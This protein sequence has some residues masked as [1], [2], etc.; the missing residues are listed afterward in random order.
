MDKTKGI[1][2]VIYLLLPL[3]KWDEILALRVYVQLRWG[4]LVDICLLE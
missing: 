3:S 1:S 4:Y 2:P